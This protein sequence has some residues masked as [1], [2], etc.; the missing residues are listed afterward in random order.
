MPGKGRMK[1]YGA[2]GK[3]MW[4]RAVTAL[5]QTWQAIGYDILNCYGGDVNLPGD[6]VQEAVSSCGF[7]GGYP[8]MYGGDPLAVEWLEKQERK[9]QD[10]VLKEAFPPN[11]NYGM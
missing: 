10:A 8:S 9:V 4:E 7:A 3:T 5:Q 11:I 1:V 6:E 2:E